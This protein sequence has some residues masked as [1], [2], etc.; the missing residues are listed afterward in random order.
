MIF[1]YLFNGVEDGVDSFH[2]N[3]VNMMSTLLLQH[4]RSPQAAVSQLLSAPTPC[5]DVP[6][7]LRFVYRRAS[8]HTD[9]PV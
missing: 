6:L 1:N 2:S 3:Q 5:A 8:V 4:G 9:A 7:R